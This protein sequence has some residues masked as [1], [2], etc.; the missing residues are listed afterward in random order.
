MDEISLNEFRKLA[1]PYAAT[2]QT[3]ARFQFTTLKAV[4]G[5]YNVVQAAIMC[6]REPA[7]TILGKK[8][9]MVTWFMF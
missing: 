9:P 1:S 2:L 4:K 5:N 7:F 8:P 6:S 3:N